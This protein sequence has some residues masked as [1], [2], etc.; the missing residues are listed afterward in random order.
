MLGSLR[1][2]LLVLKMK[3][4]LTPILQVVLRVKHESSSVKGFAVGPGTWEWPFVLSV[5]ILFFPGTPA[6]FFFTLGTWRLRVSLASPFAES[7][8]PASP[9]TGR[10]LHGDGGLRAQPKALPPCMPEWRCT[11]QRSSWPWPP[12]WTVT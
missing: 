1:L 10:P 4:T 3:I 6:C 9:L 11:Q 7:L 8:L 2:Y 5:R 12:S